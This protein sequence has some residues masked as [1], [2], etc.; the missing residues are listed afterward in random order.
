M[1]ER[2]EKALLDEGLA[3][4]DRCGRAAPI[5]EFIAIYFG[6]RGEHEDLCGRC[7]LDPDGWGGRYS[8]IHRGEENLG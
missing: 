3:S 4:C 2:F 1:N 7:L 8:I 5:K 6:E